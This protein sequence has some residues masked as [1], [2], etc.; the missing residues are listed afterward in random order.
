MYKFLQPYSC[1][2]YFEEPVWD[3]APSLATYT[4]DITKHYSLGDLLEITPVRTNLVE[5]CDSSSYGVSMHGSRA[6]LHVDIQDLCEGGIDR[7][8]GLILE[9]IHA[10]AELIIAEL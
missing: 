7:Y 1:E 2:G 10:Q 4:R 6:F 9:E 3:N 8:A 5:L